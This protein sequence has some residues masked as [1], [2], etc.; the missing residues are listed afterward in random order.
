MDSMQLP[1]LHMV[2]CLLLAEAVHVNTSLC[3]A[4]TCEVA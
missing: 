2:L 4:S 1:E 3:Q